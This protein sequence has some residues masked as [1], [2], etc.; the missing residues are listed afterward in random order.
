MILQI[1]PEPPATLGGVRAYAQRLQALAPDTFTPPVHGTRDALIGRQGPEVDAGAAAT[2]LLH[3]SNY[4]FDPA[5]R[6]DW[7]PEVVE[8]W[9]QEGRTCVV[10]FH[11]VFATGP[12]WRRAFW[13][14]SAQRSI[15]RRVARAASSALTSL[16][17]YKSLLGRL[18]P[19]LSV[20]VL[21]LLST[22]GEPYE[23]PVLSAR[24]PSLVLFGSSGLRLRAYRTFGRALGTACRAL[25]V[26]R[27]LDIGPLDDQIR[28]SAAQASTPV[29][30]RGVLE[31][32]D[33]SSALRTSRTG[34]LAY[35]PE[36][37]GKSTVYA[38]F[39]AHGLLPIV[40]W[41]ESGKPASDRPPCATAESVV[42]GDIQEIADAAHAWYEGHRAARHL[43]TYRQLF[44]H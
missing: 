7:L 33:V 21:P 17:L 27:I 34:F 39:A 43:E 30:H 20:E 31:D 40:A 32:C 10:F 29:E 24:E 4:G 6:P 2:I 22:V 28:S 9:R 1:V 42:L 35:P 12:P 18:A 41:H 14:A 11:E 15:A 16:P 25:G 5:G 26:T 37:L 19:G 13:S 44:D 3:Y 8:R 23:R 36:F 38:A